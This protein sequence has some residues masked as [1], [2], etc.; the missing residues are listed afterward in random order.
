MSDTPRPRTDAKHIYFFSSINGLRDPSRDYVPI[1]F[2]R[3]LERELAAAITRIKRLEDEL[4]EVKAHNARLI[5]SAIA[6]WARVDDEE[7]S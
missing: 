1:N 4:T 3:Q 2:S 6:A 5:D 7:R